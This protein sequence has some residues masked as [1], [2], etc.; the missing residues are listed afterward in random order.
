MS[1]H[2]ALRAARGGNRYGRA[3]RE[4]IRAGHEGGVRE[5]P[6][7]KYVRAGAAWVH[8]DEDGFASLLE[9]AVLDRNGAEDGLNAH[10]NVSV[11]LR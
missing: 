2:A 9:E 7:A 6:I 5:H 4:E 8:G 10:P 11:R 1:R 3:V